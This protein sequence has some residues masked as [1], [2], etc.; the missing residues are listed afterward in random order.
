[1]FTGPDGEEETRIRLIGTVDPIPMGVIRM[2]PRKT[3]VGDLALNEENAVGIVL[4]NDGDAPLTVT[5]IVSQKSEAE[6]YS[7]KI[8]ISPGQAYTVKFAVKPGE[9]GRYL[10]RIV[11][12]SDARNDIGKGY[13]GLLSGTV[14]E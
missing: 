5:R 14:A 13:S 2:E 1:V 6:Y 7:G 11:I 10:E 8:E 9:P 3:E 12:Y 4:E